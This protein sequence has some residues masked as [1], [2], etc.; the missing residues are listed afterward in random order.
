M[1][2][3]NWLLDLLAKTA[4][5]RS[6]CLGSKRARD[7]HW[8]TVGLLRC[9]AVHLRQRRQAPVKL[10]EHITR[11]SIWA[12]NMGRELRG[13]STYSRWFSRLANSRKGEVLPWVPLITPGFD[14]RLS[15]K[16][17]WDVYHAHLGFLNAVRPSEIS[18]RTTYVD[19]TKHVASGVLAGMDPSSAKR[20]WPAHAQPQRESN[21]AFLLKVGPDCGLR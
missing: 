1:S 15:H 4:V 20:E 11:A 14:M 10:G 12:A 5:A 13:G 18:V 2:W 9:Q 3:C 19:C 6:Y 16:D 7:Q 8:D 17:L 21:F